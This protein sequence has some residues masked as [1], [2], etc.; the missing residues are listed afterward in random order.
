[1]CINILFI[2]Q[3]QWDYSN[4]QFLLLRKMYYLLESTE[5][6]PFHWY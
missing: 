3:E 2:G 4:E 1:M 5:P 6:I